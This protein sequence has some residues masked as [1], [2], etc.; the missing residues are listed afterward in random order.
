MSLND[1]YSIRPSLIK[2]VDNINEFLFCLNRFK[3]IKQE[4]N[5]NRISENLK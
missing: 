1:A 3:K 2:L 4:A 5:I